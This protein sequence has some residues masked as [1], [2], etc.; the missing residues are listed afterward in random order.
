MIN[1]LEQQFYIVCIH[2][3][4][5]MYINIYLHMLNTV[6]WVSERTYKNETKW[7]VWYEYSLLIY[8]VEKSV[9]NLFMCVM[10]Y[11]IL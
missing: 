4:A 8:S 7:Y 6:Y 9:L 3:Y 10:W 1:I 5:A 11:G 2:M